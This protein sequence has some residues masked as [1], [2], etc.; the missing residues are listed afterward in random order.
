MIGISQCDVAS[1][2]LQQC[3]QYARAGVKSTMIVRK[4]GEVTIERNVS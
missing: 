2:D 4:T 1:R 3:C